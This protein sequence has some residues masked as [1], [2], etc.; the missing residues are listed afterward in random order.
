[1]IW[2]RDEAELSPPLFAVI[3]DGKKTSFA[4]NGRHGAA[5]LF[6]DPRAWRALNTWL[7]QRR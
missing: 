6:E 7:S 2:A 1:M 4:S 5:T 3:P